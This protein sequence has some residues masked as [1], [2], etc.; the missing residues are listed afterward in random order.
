[1][2][3]RTIVPIANKLCL[4]FEE[5]AEYSNIGENKLRELASKANC[6]FVLHNGNRKLIKR[7]EFEKF[8]ERVNC[9]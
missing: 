2:K 6:T 1:M 7:Y 4:T 8:I 9:L 5:A 3:N